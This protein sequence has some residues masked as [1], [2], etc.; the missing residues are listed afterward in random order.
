MGSS[1]IL[2]A[3]SGGDTPRPLDSHCPQYIYTE[4]PG[5]LGLQF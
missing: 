5:L 3:R 1:G 4:A 2:P